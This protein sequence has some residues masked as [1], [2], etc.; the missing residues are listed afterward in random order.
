[1]LTDVQYQEIVDLE[2]NAY[3]A[4]ATGAKVLAAKFAD[5]IQ[6]RAE[7]VTTNLQEKYEHY[8]ELAEAYDQRAREGGDGGTGVT[9][10]VANG[11]PQLTGISE[12]EIKSQR[13]DLDRYSSVFYRGVT[14]NPDTDE[15]LDRRRCR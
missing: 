9:G 10:V 13:E 14:D 12:S 11:D 1:M 3:R 5:L 4:A 7:T 15:D 6:T 8:I 2:P